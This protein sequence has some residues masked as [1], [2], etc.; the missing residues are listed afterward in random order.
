MMIDVINT[1]HTIFPLKYHKE[2]MVM[3]QMDFHTSTF[4]II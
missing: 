3:I 1:K 4:I 2:M